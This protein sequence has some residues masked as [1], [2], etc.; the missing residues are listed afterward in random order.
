V[1]EEQLGLTNAR[2]RSFSESQG[3][4]VVCVD[5]DNVL[6][7]DY[8]TQ[9]LLAFETDAQLG[10][11]G[12]KAIARYEAAPPAWFAGLDISLGCRDLG[13]APLRASWSGIAAE[14]RQY[15]I[16]AP[17]GAGMAIRRAAFAAYVA[18]TRSDPKRK[19]LGRRGSDLASGEDNDIIMSVLEQ[20]LLV[21]YL[22]QLRLDHLIPAHR[23][24]PEYLARYA[25]SSNRTWVQVLDVHGLRPW[26]RIARWTSAV[27]CARA[28][29]RN[30]AWVSEANYI[31]WR[32]ACGLIDGRSG[33]DHLPVAG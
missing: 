10:A 3:E 33:L 30:A 32:A 12:G 23:L 24:T 31:R 14:N 26:P 28:Y 1:R 6:D 9:V 7:P 16:C 5:D 17:I 20:G 8:L 11:V 2:L 4:I 29:A 19:R 18:A 25:Y 27:R 13:D 22:P 21:A 15:P